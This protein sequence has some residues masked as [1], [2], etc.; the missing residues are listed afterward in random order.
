MM[1]ENLQPQTREHSCKVRTVLMQ[2]ETADRDA[3][4]GY[5]DDYD[6]WTANGLSKALRSR[7][8]YISANTIQKHRNEACSC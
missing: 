3:L 5:L 2:L 4:Q 6:T 8:V 7:N 1:L